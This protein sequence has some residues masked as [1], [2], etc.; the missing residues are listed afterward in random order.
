M[1]DNGTWKVDSHK[2]SIW[3]ESDD[4][5][6]DVILRINGDFESFAERWMYAVDIARRLND[7]R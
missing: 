6:H 3:V 5:T 7:N 1:S 2:D 4:S